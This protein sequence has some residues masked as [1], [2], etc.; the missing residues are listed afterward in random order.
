ML[1]GVIPKNMRRFF[2]YAQ[3]II[4][5]WLFARTDISGNLVAEARLLPKTGEPQVW[6]V[7]KALPPLLPTD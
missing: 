1:P 3:T 6:A 7:G 5:L 4:G 2:P